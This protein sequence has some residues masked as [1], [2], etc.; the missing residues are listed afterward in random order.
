MKPP[1]PDPATE[2]PAFDL[3]RDGFRQMPN[4]RQVE[5]L[6]EIIEQYRR[7]L[8]KRT[9]A[10]L[11]PARQTEL[12]AL[13]LDLDDR[14]TEWANNRERLKNLRR[15]SQR[16]P[17][18]VRKLFAALQKI[19]LALDKLERD[20]KRL[21]RS[22]AHAL[23]PSI[24]QARA[25][26]TNT[27]LIRPGDTIDQYVARMPTWHDD[28]LHSSGQVTDPKAFAAQSLVSYLTDSCG[29][30][31][32]D[33]QIRTA[34][35]GNALWNWKLT[36]GKNDHGAP[37]CPTLRMWLTRARKTRHRTESKKTR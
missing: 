32:G 23:G 5:I 26:L 16:G 29:L 8:P 28:A 27:H 6:T 24:K 7:K 36:I 9:L 33:A 34:N 21:D 35:I 2:I 25:N 18:H 11:E 10:N 15:L 20:S 1:R 19:L 22:I 30:P 4:P 17:G 31:V 13:V 14:H 37:D 12:T 3:V